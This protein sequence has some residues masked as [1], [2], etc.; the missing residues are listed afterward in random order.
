VVCG[1]LRV[2]C[3]SCFVIALGDSTM[4]NALAGK[5]RWILFSRLNKSVGY[6]LWLYV[7]LLSR[8]KSCIFKKLNET[9]TTQ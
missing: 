5:K 9:D 3:S 2:A 1:S 6:F 4:F 8:T 7:Y